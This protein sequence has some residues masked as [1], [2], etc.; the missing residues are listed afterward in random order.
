[1]YLDHRL[2]V[3]EIKSIIIR[4]LTEKE[5]LKKSLNKNKIITYE[6]IIEDEKLVL[7]FEKLKDNFISSETSL[8]AFKFLFS[9]KPLNNVKKKIEWLKVAKNGIVNKKSITDFIGVL[10]DKEIISKPTTMSKNTEIKIFDT[11]FSSKNSNLKFSTS[12]FVTPIKK[13]QHR[14]ELETIINSIYNLPPQQSKV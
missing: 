2:Y 3:D 6:W 13:S 4:L 9:G 1:L 11:L 7:L 14:S 8:S 12:N 5:V 10:F